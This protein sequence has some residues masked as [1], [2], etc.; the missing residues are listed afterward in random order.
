MCTFRDH[1]N[2]DGCIR[3]NAPLAMFFDFVV[4]SFA[5]VAA[6]QQQSKT[7]TLRGGR[8]TITSSRRHK[9]G[10]TKSSQWLGKS[11]S[12]KIVSIEFVCSVVRK[13]KWKIYNVIM[14]KKSLDNQHSLEWSG[15]RRTLFSIFH[16]WLTFSLNLILARAINNLNPFADDVSLSKLFIPL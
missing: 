10:G 15:D 8:W 6:G 12:I 5:D 3:A 1:Q 13:N 7:G 14:I 9:S 4:V 11:R 16:Y 2:F